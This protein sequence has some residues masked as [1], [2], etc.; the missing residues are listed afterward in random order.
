MDIDNMTIE[1]LK[2]ELTRYK[3]RMKKDYISDENYAFQKGLWYESDQEYSYIVIWSPD[4]KF[5]A[6]FTDEKAKEYLE[7]N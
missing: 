6:Y 5:N 1:E 2:A 4:Y 7:E 3:V